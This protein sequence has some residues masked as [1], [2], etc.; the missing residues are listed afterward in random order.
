MELLRSIGNPLICLPI[1][2]LGYG[3]V[4][5]SY[6]MLVLSIISLVMNI[7]YCVQ[8]LKLGFI[9]KDINWKLLIE[10][11]SVKSCGR[12]SNVRV[13]NA[14]TFWWFSYFKSCASAPP[15]SDGFTLNSFVIKFS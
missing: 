7:Y 15:K 1:L 10:R 11:L 3:S 4:G 14:L 8:K 2:L 12:C 6:V 5:M 9:F 13:V